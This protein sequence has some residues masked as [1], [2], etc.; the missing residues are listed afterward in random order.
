MDAIPASALGSAVVA[1]DDPDMRLY[2]SSTLRGMGF[3]TVYEA[4]DGRSALRMAH[5]DSVSLVV[6]DY[7]MPGLDGLAVCDALKADADTAE[8]P[9]LLITGQV[10]VPPTCSDGFLPK[11]FNAAKLRS[12][13]RDLLALN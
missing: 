6:S 12:A 5:N 9:F 1:D 3:E 2:L 11:P 10:R 7:L 8:I 4:A 13:V